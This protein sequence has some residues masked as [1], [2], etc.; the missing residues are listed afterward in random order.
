MTDSTDDVDW[1]DFDML[2]DSY[3]IDREAVKCSYN[4]WKTKT[5]EAIKITAMETSH[6]LRTIKYLEDVCMGNRPKYLKA[7]DRLVYLL[8]MKFELLK[9]ELGVK[10]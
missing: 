3:E 6:L 9:R 8:N 5:G 7:E 2:D 4:Y 1:F 10:K